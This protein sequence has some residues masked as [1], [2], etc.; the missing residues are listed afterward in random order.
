MCF[1]LLFA[2]GLVSYPGAKFSYVFFTG[3]FFALGLSAFFRQ[4]SYGY[5]F[6]ALFLWLG[7]WLKATIHFLF[8]YPYLEPTGQFNF[9]PEGWDLVLNASSAGA[10]GLLAARLVYVLAGKRA[11]AAGPGAAYMP[12]SW[13]G[14]ARKW[15]WPAL[16]LFTAGIA[17][18]NAASGIHQVGLYPRTILP[19]PG[20]A[21]IAWTLNAG[22]PMLIA[23]FAF[24]D[25]SSGRSLLPGLA[26]IAA[27]S[28]AYSMS[29]LSRGAF[30]YHAAPLLAAIPWGRTSAASVSKTRLI[31]VSVLFLGAFSA[32]VIFVNNYRTGLYSGA[33]AAQAAQAAAKAPEPGLLNALRRN[34]HLRQASGLFIDRWIG[35]EGVMAVSAYPEKSSGLLWKEL[36]GRRTLTEKS[37]YE[38]ICGSDFQTVDAEKHQFGRSPG[39]VGLFY[40]SGRIWLVFIGLFGLGLLV[41]YFESAVWLL[42]KNPLMCSLLGMMAANNAA[43]LGPA[44]GQLLPTYVMVSFALVAIWFLENK[45][46]RGVPGPGSGKK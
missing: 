35:L 38:R 2:A 16:I 31:F 8:S 4:R 28:I 17:V 39:P 5:I 25:L 10:L 7:F 21:L 6:L 33:A 18:F 30:I 36:T 34:K 12:P 42:T 32:S 15:L 9:T 24:R 41:L 46:G 44:P 11:A 13:Y 27:E 1:A 14:P 22:A 45:A 37:L 40:Y 43:Q 3:L 26:A 29:V 20:N 23:V 19:W